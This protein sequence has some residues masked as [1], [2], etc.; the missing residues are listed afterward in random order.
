MAEAQIM[1]LLGLDA[2]VIGNFST[3]NPFSDVEALNNPD[4]A[5]DYKVKA[6]QIYNLGYVSDEI[7]DDGE[8]TGLGSIATNLISSATNAEGQLNPIDLTKTDDLSSFF[9]IYEDQGTTAV[10]SA[11]VNTL[12][13]IVSSGNEEIRDSGAS[14]EVLSV[15]HSD[16]SL[17]GLATSSVTDSDFDGFRN[18]LH[19]RLA[20]DRGPDEGGS[21]SVVWQESDS[22]VTDSQM[23]RLVEEYLGIPD[24]SNSQSFNSLEES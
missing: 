15:I 4:A 20:V 24:L 8:F 9:K 17:D 11:A 7:V 1:T 21:A 6:A 3:Y 2:D 19:K 23:T 22:E 10:S 14:Q 5:T 13:S 18:Q 12:I 16:Q